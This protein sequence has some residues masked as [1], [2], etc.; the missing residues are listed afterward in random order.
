MRWNVRPS[1]PVAV[2][3]ALFGA[4]IVVFGVATMGRFT[5]FTALWVIAGAAIVLF[6]LWAAFSPR[7]SVYSA[8]LSSDDVQRRT[9]R[10]DTE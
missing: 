1:K 9:G 3:G 5:A 2:F 10:N 7:G 8:E 6:N 4:A